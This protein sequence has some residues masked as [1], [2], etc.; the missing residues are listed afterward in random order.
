MLKIAKEERKRAEARGE[1]DEVE[2]E[3][4]LKDDKTIFKDIA[5]CDYIVENTNLDMALFEIEK[6]Y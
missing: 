1:F 3:R 2:W 5:K 4:R 6:N